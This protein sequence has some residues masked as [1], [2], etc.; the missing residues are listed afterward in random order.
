MVAGPPLVRVVQRAH[1]YRIGQSP[2]GEDE[3]QLA[4][5]G[6]GRLPARVVR[7]DVPACRW[8]ARPATG[9]LAVRVGPGA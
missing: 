7:G 1:P 6:G 2:G 3:V 9:P 4:G 8:E 5:R